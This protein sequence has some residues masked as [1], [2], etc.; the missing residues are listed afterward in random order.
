[1]A[2][3]WD[4][5]MAFYI[6]AYLSDTMHLAREHHGSYLLLIMAAFK[7]AGWLPNDDGLLMQIAKCTAKEWK[8]ERGIYAALFQVTDE[9]WTHKRVTI[10]WDK[11]Q[12]LTDQRRAAGTA[13]ATSRKRSFN[14]RSTLVEAESQRN[15]RHSEEPLKGSHNQES[16]TASARESAGGAR[17]HDTVTILET[18][19]EKKRA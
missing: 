11:A 15:D 4:V 6:G 13:S 8:A 14:A 17:T 16:P 3:T 2:K 5:W 10:E 9:R 19:A 18:L 1:M 12:R 7:N